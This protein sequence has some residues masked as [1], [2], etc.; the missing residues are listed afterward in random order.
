MGKSRHCQSSHPRRRQPAQ[1]PPVERPEHGNLYLSGLS[2]DVTQEELCDFLKNINCDHYKSIWKMPNKR[3]GFI[4]YATPDEALEAMK[5]LDQIPYKQQKLT[6]RPAYNDYSAVT[7][8][9]E[10]M[11]SQNLYVSGLDD[12]TQGNDILKRFGPHGKVLNARLLHHKKNRCSAIVTMGSTEEA[13]SV[14]N[15]FHGETLMPNKGLPLLVQYALP[16]AARERQAR[17]TPTS[18]SRSYSS[19][20]ECCLA[21]SKDVLA[22]WY[23][24]LQRQKGLAVL[25][26]ACCFGCCDTLLATRLRRAA[27]SRLHLWYLACG[28]CPWAFLYTARNSSIS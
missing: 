11:P 10:G 22:K 17:Q 24:I 26:L 21:R 16:S 18:H 27:V 9:Y 28:V 25:L 5:K 15:W 20:R 14:I 23:S 7:K 6:V 3:Y 1:A 4:G 8:N 19:H 2:P 12:S 13:S